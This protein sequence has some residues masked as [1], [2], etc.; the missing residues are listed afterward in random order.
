MSVIN[1]N[2]HIMLLFRHPSDARRTIKHTAS[3]AFKARSEFTANV[4]GRL[5]LHLLS[6]LNIAPRELRTNL[7]LWRAMHGCSYSAYGRARDGLGQMRL[8]SKILLLRWCD[9][10]CC[11]WGFVRC[12]NCPQSSGDVAGG[13]A[14]VERRSLRAG[15]CP[16]HA[17]GIHI[18]PRLFIEG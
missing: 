3:V 4:S 7:P 13:E 8:I 17:R 16:Q 1:R 9:L 10:A 2:L 5:T 11:F 14:S 12:K 18:T 15:M 6:D